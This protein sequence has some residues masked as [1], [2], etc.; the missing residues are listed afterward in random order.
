MVKPGFIL[1][2][3]IIAMLIIASVSMTALQCMQMMNAS[4]ARFAANHAAVQARRNAM[5]IVRHLGRTDRVQAG[6]VQYGD[7]EVRW[8]AELAETINFQRMTIAGPAPEM[9]LPVYRVRVTTE[10]EGRA[11]DAFDIVV[12]S[13]AAPGSPPSLGQPPSPPR[14]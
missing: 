14:R 2:E 11:I 9:Q 10:R 4:V 1:L 3:A 6:S 7:V 8:Q 5:A 13:S 12:T